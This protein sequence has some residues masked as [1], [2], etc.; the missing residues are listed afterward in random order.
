MNVN[1]LPQLNLNEWKETRDT[2]HKY[3]QM[4]SAIRE[5]MS[6]PLPN[7]EH[8]CLQITDRG[9]TSTPLMKERNSPGKMFEVVLDINNHILLIDSNYRE[10]MQVL[11]TGQSLSALCDETCSLLSDI[12]VSIP[13]EKPSFI[14]GTQRRYN[15]QFAA[16]YWQA[17]KEVNRIF[18]KYR[19]ELDK[20]RSPVEVWPDH[21]N[22]VLS[23]FPGKVISRNEYREEDSVEEKVIFGFSTGDDSI[24]EAF[25]Y[26]MVG[27]ASDEFTNIG[28][29]EEP[30]WNSTNFTGGVLLYKDVLKAE[31]PEEKILN[32][33]RTFKHEAEKLLK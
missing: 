29:A 13:I 1:K 31:D 4:V 8:V 3:S 28:P 5:T 15:P 16:A 30:K 33:F 12:G 32:F 19:D 23:W 17:L 21:F 18:N 27:Q 2:L 6:Q 26:A 7:G 11:L 9:L 24:N 25:F 14:D 20:E 10:K 22:M